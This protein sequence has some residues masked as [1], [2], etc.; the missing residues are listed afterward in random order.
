MENE[1]IQI[2]KDISPYNTAAYGFVVLLL[3]IGCYVFYKQWMKWQDKYITSINETIKLLGEVNKH[4]D[5]S[6]NNDLCLREIKF[7]IEKLQDYV[8]NIR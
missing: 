8:R 5:K 7:E 1:I 3:L 6:E 4:L 2:T